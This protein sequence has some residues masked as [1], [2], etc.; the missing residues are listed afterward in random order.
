MREVATNCCC[1]Y[2]IR[3]NNFGAL[4]RKGA[5]EAELELFTV[6]ISCGIGTPSKKL[7]SLK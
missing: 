1:C 5:V 7:D 4:N 2:R 3:G 6:R